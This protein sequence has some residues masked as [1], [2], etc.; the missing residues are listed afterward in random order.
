MGPVLPGGRTEVKQV[1]FSVP[2]AL[3]WSERM[4]LKLAGQNVV[5]GFKG[6]PV[7]PPTGMGEAVRRNSQRLRFS[8]ASPSAS[9]SQSSKMWYPHSVKQQQVNG[10]AG[11]FDS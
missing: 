10:L 1:E 4:N 5:I 8:A 3:A 6:E 7:P 11:A 2:G 9:R